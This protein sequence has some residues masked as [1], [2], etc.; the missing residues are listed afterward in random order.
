MR[1]IIRI[2][3]DANR[4]WVLMQQDTKLRYIV[5]EHE[6]SVGYWVPLCIPVETSPIPDQ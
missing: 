1:C 4:S 6:E 5:T 2:P 3:D